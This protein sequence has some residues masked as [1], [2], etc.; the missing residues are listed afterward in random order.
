MKVYYSS[1]GELAS[2]SDDSI[3]LTTEDTEARALDI[4]PIATGMTNSS[5][6]LYQDDLT[7]NIAHNKSSAS[8]IVVDLD[9]S[10]FGGYPDYDTEIFYFLVRK[11]AAF[12]VYSSDC[13]GASPGAITFVETI[14]DFLVPLSYDVRVQQFWKDESRKTYFMMS[15]THLQWYDFVKLAWSH[16]TLV[17]PT[18][19]N[20]VG[21][22]LGAG[23][24]LIIPFLMWSIYIIE[25]TE[26]GVLRKIQAVP[27]N[28]GARRT[29]CGR[30]PGRKRSR[31]IPIL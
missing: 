22:D 9:D 18:K 21:W 28:I 25:I 3:T 7:L 20:G 17:F 11:D 6:V 4:M 1:T 30:G 15:N 23:N 8:S 29:F 14:S 13:S 16:Y 24:R 27:N 2:W 31:R 19:V 12:K 10:Y 26:K 5:P